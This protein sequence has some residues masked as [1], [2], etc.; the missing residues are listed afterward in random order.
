VATDF[1]GRSIPNPG[2]AGDSGAADAALAAALEAHAGGFS[3]PREVMAALAAARVLVP[4]VAVLGE[5]ED[6]AE[7]ALRREKSADM[8]LPTLIGR[9]GRKALPVF[10]SLAALAA[11]D[12]SARPVPVETA[13]AA[14]S[15][16]SEGCTVLVVDVAGP[17]SFVA[18]RPQL[19]ALAQQRAWLPAYDDRDVIAAVHAAVAGEPAS[20]SVAPGSEGEPELVV[21]LDI[22]DA[23]SRAVAE[24]VA[25]R[26]AGDPVIRERTSRGVAVA[27]RPA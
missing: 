2:F 4:V 17:H 24:R 27:V 26:L 15:A 21:T 16:V 5:E 22:G 11:W 9:D 14:L 19:W 20:A 25:Q 18:E 7:G 1:S 10:T 23:D 13:R 12:A 3:T 6:V 8:A